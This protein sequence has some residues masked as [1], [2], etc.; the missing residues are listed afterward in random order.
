MHCH[1]IYNLSNFFKLLVYKVIY[2]INYHL[3]GL[4][5]KISFR[6]GEHAVKSHWNS[7]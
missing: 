6:V 5:N 4:R 1:G 2:W 7:K 3:K